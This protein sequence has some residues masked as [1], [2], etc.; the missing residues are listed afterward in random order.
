MNTAS[1]VTTNVQIVRDRV[2][3]GV[4]ITVLLGQGREVTGH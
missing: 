2:A 1:D 3:G 4:S